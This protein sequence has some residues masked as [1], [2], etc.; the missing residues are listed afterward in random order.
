MKKKGLFT[1]SLL[2][3]LVFLSFANVSVAAPPS[4]V[5]VKT[6]DEFTWTASLNM[7]N[8]NATAIAIFGLDNWTLMY[9]YFLEWFENQTTMEFDFLAGAGMRAVLTNVS[10]EIPHPYMPGFLCSGLYFD[11]Y[12]AYAADNWT[13]VTNSSMYSMPM[14][15]L[16]D[17]SSL[18]ESTIMYG[19]MG[20]PLFMPIGFNYTMF[21]GVYQ[22]YIDS[23][24]Y[25]AGNFTVQPHGNGL[26]MILKASYI[27]LMVNQSG[28]PFTLGTLTDA[29]FTVRWNSNGVL[30]YGDLKYG[31][32]T[33]ATAELIPSEDLIPGFELMT[34][35]GVSI[36]SI[37][38]IIYIQR[39]KHK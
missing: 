9:E 35:I 31:G 18:N 33:L 3:M 4:Y 29:I 14:I 32:L 21:A 28:L 30:D 12:T 13:M 23:S 19:F 1:V 5:G 25:T 26:K 39:K 34:I 8:L 2:S 15:C 10:D 17:P 6:G 37:L 22:T 11:I 20:T 38:A 27:E 7:V 36:T 24:P 16:V